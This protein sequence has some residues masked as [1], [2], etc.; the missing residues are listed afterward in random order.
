M[1]KIITCINCQNPFF[2]RRDAK[3]CS[4]RCRKALQRNRAVAE[5]VTGYDVPTGYT[6][7]PKHHSAGTSLTARPVAA[8]RLRNSIVL[9]AAGTLLLAINFS[10]VALA[11]VSQ[12]YVTNDTEL[13][14]YMA[15]KLAGDDAEGHPVVQSSSIQDIEKTIGIAVGLGDSLLTVAPVS[16]EVYIVAS[17]P[18]KAY[19]SDI[20]GAVKR[21]DLLAISPL[22]GVLMKS[23]D[24]TLPTIGQALDDFIS[25]KTQTI[26][27]QDA[28][29]KPVDVHV[30]IMSM[31]VSIK[32][33]RAT[34]SEADNSWVKSFGKSLVGHEISTVRVIAALAI[35]FTLMVIEGELVYGTIAS[36]I[37][38]IGR[39]PLAR[40]SIVAQSFRS[41]RMA[42]VILT[43]GIG[44]VA[45]L[46]WL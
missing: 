16:S 15:V 29:K 46:L 14:Q 38:A 5:R 30:A 42:L 22:R 13:R 36:S 25:Q 18:T 39:N 3:T 27:A 21:G 7:H 12:G 9:L 33:A 2:G 24:G 19:I 28:D 1:S 20:N 6:H 40:K 23:T 44:S 26:I 43:L 45:L 17:G 10:G 4:M 41:V 8:R 37:T 32:P 34:S 35:F 31:N 11:A